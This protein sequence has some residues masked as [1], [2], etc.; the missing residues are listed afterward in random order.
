MEQALSERKGL[1]YDMML[2]QLGWMDQQGAPLPKRA[3]ARPLSTLCLLACEGMGGDHS[4]AVP[5][6]AALELVHTF[7]VVHGDVQ[8]GVPPSDD[9]PSVWWAWGPGQAINVGDGLHAL[10]RAEIF[11]LTENGVAVEKVMSALNALDQA[12]LRMCEGQYM[13][14]AFQERLDVTVGAYLKMA[15]AKGGALMSCAAELGAMIAT[16]DGDSIGCLARAGVKLGVAA[17]IQRDIREL[18]PLDG[19]RPEQVGVANKKKSFP[20]VQALE[21]GA[22][23]MKRQ[24]GT[25]YFKRVLEPPDVKALRDLLDEAKARESAQVV[26]EKYLNEALEAA[27][28]SGIS[29]WGREQFEQLSRSLV[30]AG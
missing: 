5:A 22:V 2:Y 23:S 15:E 14:L 28:E 21:E 30:E 4:M 8:D 7:T 25:I 24:I 10:G 9:R 18:W 16:E 3:E 20:V 13:E 11:R 6:A 12:C 27:E 17:Q 19:E 26:S 1:L 29:P